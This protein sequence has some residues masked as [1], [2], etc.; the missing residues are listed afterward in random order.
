MDQKRT[1]W[2]WLTV[3]LAG[4]VG[5]GCGKG[6]DGR[7]TP[8]AVSGTVFFNQQPSVGAKIM[9]APQD[10]EY[11]AVGQTDSNGR[12]KLQTFEPDDGAVPGKF[13]IAVTKFEVIE[14]PNGGIKENFFLPGR[15]RDPAKSGLVATVPPEGANDLRIELAE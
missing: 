7:P 8:V 2:F 15:Y 6:V 3:A 13:K 5:P 9:F 12:F 10:H 1:R 11:A 4:M 14:L